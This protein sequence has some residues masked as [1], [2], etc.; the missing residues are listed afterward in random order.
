ML[1]LEFAKL[2]LKPGARAAQMSVPGFIKARDRARAWAA[3]QE[4]KSVRPKR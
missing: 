3:E 1:I 4:A 2:G